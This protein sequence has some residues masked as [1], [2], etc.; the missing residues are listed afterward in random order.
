LMEIAVASGS[1]RKI[2]KRRQRAIKA[3][4]AYLEKKRKAFARARGLKREEIIMIW[5]GDLKLMGKLS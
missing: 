1:Y 4:E 3:M 2:K 5:A